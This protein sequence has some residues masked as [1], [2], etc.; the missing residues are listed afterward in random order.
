MAG[1]T[2]SAHFD[3]A[4][5]AKLTATSQVEGRTHSQIVAVA[6]KFYLELSPGARRALVAMDTGSAIEREYFNRA[7][8]RAAMKAREKLIAAKHLLDYKP[9]TNLSLDT[10]EAIESEAVAALRRD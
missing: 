10:E 1:K 3:E 2:R 7:V 5:D 4:L 6:T 8:G 9:T